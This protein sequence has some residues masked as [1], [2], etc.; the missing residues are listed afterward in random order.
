MDSKIEIYQALW[1]SFFGLRLTI[2]QALNMGA[3]RGLTFEDAILLNLIAKHTKMSVKDVALTSGRDVAALSRQSTRLVSRGWLI[4]TRSKHDARLCIMSVTQR[5]T[6]ALP[7]I[8][9][10][11]ERVID[12]CVEGLSNTERYELVRMLF[13]VKDKISTIKE[14]TQSDNE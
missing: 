11:I 7:Q 9:E 8:N 13:M 14:L 4:K 1:H 2:D 3:T 12:E 6:D 5:T 10:T